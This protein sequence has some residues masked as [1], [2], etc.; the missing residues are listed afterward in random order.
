MTT[1]M[2]IA[3]GKMVIY[4]EIPLVIMKHHAKL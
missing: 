4:L 1:I 3:V 2:K